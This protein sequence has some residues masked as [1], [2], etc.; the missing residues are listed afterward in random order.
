MKNPIAVVTMLAIVALGGAGL[1]FLVRFADPE[2]AATHI[3]NMIAGV[4]CLSL[5]TIILII[6]IFAFRKN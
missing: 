2:Y 3:A 4:V 5:A 6:S 1:F